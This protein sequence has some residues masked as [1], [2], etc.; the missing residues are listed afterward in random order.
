MNRTLLILLMVG[1]AMLITVIG[2]RDPSVHLDAMPWEVVKLE[3]G[4]LRV[5]GITLEKTTIQEANQIFADFAD[6]RLQVIEAPQ[7]QQIQ[8]V[9]NY[10]DL[11]I[12]GLSAQLKLIYLVEPNE[13][14]TIFQ[15]IDKTKPIKETYLIDDSFI[16]SYPVAD[17]IKMSYLNKRISRIIYIPSIDYSRETIQQNFGI[18]AQEEKYNENTQIWHYPEM[19]LKIYILQDKPDHFV[20]ESP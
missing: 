10:D 6:T 17:K 13:L 8:L 15:S 1:T 14:Q 12:G 16:T 4:S 3:N 20:Y 11:S 7:N 2:Q 5:F 9:A 19:G 18:A